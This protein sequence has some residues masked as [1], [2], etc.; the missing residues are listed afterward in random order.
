[1]DF[2]HLGQ[3]LRHAASS[4]GR[5]TR[6]EFWAFVAL[7]ALLIACAASLEIRLFG[8]AGFP[9]PLVLG[10]A[11]L[12]LGPLIAVAVRR[13]HDIGRQGHWLFLVFVPVLGA[14]ILIWWF[15]I[16]SEARRNRHGP[17]PLD[18]Y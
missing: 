14:V 10:V 9:G 12:L 7:A 15:C 6:S 5:A 1:M 17:D 18:T 2:P 8:G 11:A 4:R 13:L 3:F 16:Q